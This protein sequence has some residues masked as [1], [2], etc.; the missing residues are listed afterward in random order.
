M[1]MPSTSDTPSPRPIAGPPPAPT[2]AAGAPSAAPAA[3][4]AKPSARKS[5]NAEAKAVKAYLDA[6]D[7][8]GRTAELRDAELESLIRRKEAFEAKAAEA[9]SWQRLKIYSSIE[10]IED[11]LDEHGKAKKAAERLI[12]LE[13]GFIANAASYARTAD[14]PPQRFARLGIEARVLAAAGLA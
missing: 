13:P 5:S 11:R 7:V 9:S 3:R 2:Q 10:E 1:P 8:C 6:I 12:Q 14:I 4:P